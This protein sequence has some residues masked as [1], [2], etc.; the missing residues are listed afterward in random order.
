MRALH[1]FITTLFVV[2]LC[3]FCLIALYKHY[4][5]D[6]S[7]GV[8]TVGKATNTKAPVILP[9]TEDTSKYGEFT[10]PA[11]YRK[12]ATDKIVTPVL[13][14][15]SYITSGTASQLSIQVV[16]LPG[17]SLS[18]DGTYNYRNVTKDRYTKSTVMI[19]GKPSVMFADTQAASRAVYLQKGDLVA[20]IALTGV[21]GNDATVIIDV[22]NDWH[23]L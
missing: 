9:S 1:R 3:S 14:N 12:I 8:I 21:D 7:E 16:Q 5:S 15:F 13:E 20:R 10:V 18:E 23:W 11:G 19:S 6:S 17:G 2:M 22:A 4:F